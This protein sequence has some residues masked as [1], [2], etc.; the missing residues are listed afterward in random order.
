VEAT[1][2]AAVRVVRVFGVNN[3]RS[4]LRKCGVEVA[5]EGAKISTDPS[6]HIFV[7]F[8]PFFG[9]IF[10]IVEDNSRSRGMIKL[11][12]RLHLPFT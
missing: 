5:V 2:C 9:C 6:P 1:S 12:F 10:I 8:G 11:L 4:W 3:K 7:A